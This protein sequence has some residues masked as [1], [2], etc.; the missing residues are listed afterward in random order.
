MFKITLTAARVNAGYSL[1]EV[2]KLLRKSKST[3]IS[4]EKG[5]NS[6]RASDFKELCELYKIP[7]DFILLPDTLQNVEENKK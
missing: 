2:A 6:I 1:D 5:K 4:W 3:V 7:M